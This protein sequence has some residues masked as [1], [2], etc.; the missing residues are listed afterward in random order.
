M[1]VSFIKKIVPGLVLL[2]ALVLFCVT[3]HAQEDRQE[4]LSGESSAYNT[5]MLRKNTTAMMDAIERDHP[6]TQT[7]AVI[8]ENAQSLRN[9]LPSQELLDQ[10]EAIYPPHGEG[11]APISYG[12]RR[13]VSGEEIFDRIDSRA[14]AAY[15]DQ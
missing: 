1:L 4:P 5:E 13:H 7:V 15:Y 11:G 14:S 9:H 6:P 2:P 10:V 12:L 8:P 3:A